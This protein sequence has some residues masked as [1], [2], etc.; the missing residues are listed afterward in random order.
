MPAATKKGGMA[1][2]MPDVCLTPSGPSPV[3]VP[4]PNMGQLNSADGAIAKVMMENKETIVEDS[5]L[6]SSSGDEA[7]TVGGVMSG[8][9]RGEVQFKTYSSKV[10]AKGKKIVCHT[11]VTAHNGSNANLPAGAHVAPSQAKVIVGM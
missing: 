5:K 8:M 1:M 10:Y 2:G 6:P 9:N 3:P 11:A 4:Y 7:G